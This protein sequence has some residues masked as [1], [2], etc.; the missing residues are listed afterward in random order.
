MSEM[1]IKAQYRR[2]IV[3]IYRHSA[4][5]ATWGLAKQR[6]TR[7]VEMASGG[8]GPSGRGCVC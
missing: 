3:H 4:A 6:V 7:E 1:F 2:A 8:T 5:P